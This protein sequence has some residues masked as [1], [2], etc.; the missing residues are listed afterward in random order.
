[1]NKQLMRIQEASAL[2]KMSEAFLELVNIEKI[3]YNK[4][5]GIHK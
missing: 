4:S 2:W 5:Y 3:W 1:M